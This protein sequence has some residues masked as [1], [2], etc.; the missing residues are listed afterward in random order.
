MKTGIL[1][2][3]ALS[4]CAAPV[5]ARPSAPA[6]PSQAVASAP[7]APASVAP[8][9]ALAARPDLSR[10]ESDVAAMTGGS[11]AVDHIGPQAF[12]EVL[13]R[14]RSAPVAYMAR[15][16][17]LASKADAKLLASMH[18]EH[19]VVRAAETRPSEAAE[20]ART[21]LPHYYAAHAQAVT[22]P[23]WDGQ[24]D[25]LDGKIAALTAVARR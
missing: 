18:F 4:A 15:A 25:L 22:A 21:M 23:V 11:F 16:D 14:F 19:V 9:A 3:L 7:L 24:F 13:Q 6:P 20:V 2:V 1:L 17:A 10:L 8:S 12:E 5:A